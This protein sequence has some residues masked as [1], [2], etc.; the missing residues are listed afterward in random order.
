M[1]EPKMMNDDD[2]REEVS[3]E[4][5]SEYLEKAKLFAN[6][7]RSII[8]SEVDGGRLEPTLK[9]DLSLV[10]NADKAAEKVFSENVKKYYPD[11]GIIGEEF[12]ED[13]P[14][15]HTDFQWIIDPIDGTTEFVHEIPVYG[16][17]IALH[18]KKKP[19]VGLLDHSALDVRCCGAFGL[20]VTLGDKKITLSDLKPESDGSER[21]VI[22]AP[23]NFR[24]FK[25]TEEFFIRVARAYPNLR[26]LHGCFAQTCTIAGSYDAMIEWNVREWDVAAAQVLV[27]EARGKYRRLPTPEDG[28][29]HCAVFG[30]PRV[31]SSISRLFDKQK[32]SERTPN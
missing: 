17:I 3:E 27:E 25:G 11:H 14:H 1:T 21:V 7:C 4:K 28:D 8:Q 22:S 5:R 12:L 32:H 23:D 26:I 6:D 29:V 24:R 18:Y 20:G 2:I 10:T 15:P 16:T 19:L 31:V 30:K 13:N 9:R